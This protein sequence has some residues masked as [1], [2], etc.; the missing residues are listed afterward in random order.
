MR[1]S[2]RVCIFTSMCM[3]MPIL[4]HILT[5]THILMTVLISICMSILTVMRMCMCM[6]MSMRVQVLMCRVCAY[7]YFCVSCNFQRYKIDDFNLHTYICVYLRSYL[8]VCLYVY[9]NSSSEYYHAHIFACL[10][11][12]IF[13]RMPMRMLI[14]KNFPLTL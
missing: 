12:L 4:I 13:M 2:V 9:R 8:C 5:P 6:C 14:S 3:L 11:M 7:V 1:M 10:L